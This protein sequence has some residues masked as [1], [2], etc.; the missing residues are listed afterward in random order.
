MLRKFFT[1]WLRTYR[2]P[3]E[4]R[5][6]RASVLHLWAEA[7]N[8]DPTNVEDLVRFNE[9]ID[10]SIAESVAFFGTKMTEDRNLLLGMLDHDMRGP[11]HVIQMTATLLA[12][13]DAGDQVSTMAS[14]IASSGT[15]LKTLLD[16]LIDFNRT[17]L[18]LGIHIRPMRVDLGELFADALE[19]LRAEYPGRVIDLQ[20][21]GDV[22]GVWDAHRMHQLFSN[23]V[24]NALRYGDANST[25]K[26]SI[27]AI[28]TT[29]EFCVMNRGRTMEAPVM[30]HIVN[31]LVRSG[32]RRNGTEGEGSVGLGLYIAQQIALAHGG[33]IHVHSD[34]ESTRFGG[35]PNVSF[36]GVRNGGE[37]C[38]VHA[39]VSAAN[40]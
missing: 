1:P 21:S 22:Q 20:I 29:V 6:L 4:Y 19:Q 14:R 8:P 23:L 28:P 25:V 3:R 12:K 34:V 9:A 11:L 39:G 2:R 10:Q 17:H 32:E 7:C 38:Q 35:H 40:G 24:A 18:R 5:A 31:R 37:R 26:I 13:V 36:G 27:V 33:D 30:N 15:Q 16:K